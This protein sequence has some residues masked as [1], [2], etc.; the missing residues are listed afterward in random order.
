MQIEV[1]IDQD[2]VEL[3]ADA[4]QAHRQ[5]ERLAAARGGEPEGGGCIDPRIG[6]A[7]LRAAQGGINAGLEA[8][9]LDHGVTRILENRGACAAG[10]RGEI[11][12]GPSP[13]AAEGAA[14]VA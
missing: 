11:P 9:R 1:S 6:R 12:V 7:A 13:L 5:F 2:G 3:I 4:E 10:L 14:A 8:A